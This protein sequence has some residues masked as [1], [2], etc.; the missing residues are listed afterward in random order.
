MNPTIKIHEILRDDPD[1]PLVLKYT[2]S[3]PFENGAS[4]RH[5]RAKVGEAIE[6][7]VEEE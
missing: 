3:V 5:G 7:P 1:A 2:I 6:I 4:L